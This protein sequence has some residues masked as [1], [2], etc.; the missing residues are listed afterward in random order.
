MPSNPGCPH[1]PRNIQV[2]KI[3]NVK[4][5][6]C[7]N[8]CVSKMFSSLGDGEMCRP[9]IVSSPVPFLDV[10]NSRHPCISLTC[11]GD[12]F[13]P[14]DVIINGGR[15]PEGSL[16]VVV[17]GPNM[18]GKST[19]M[20]QTGLLVILA[21]LV[22]GHSHSLPL[23]L[24]LSLFLSLSLLF[25]TMY[26]RVWMFKDLPLSVRVAMCQPAVVLSVQL[27]ESSPGLERLTKSHL[28]RIQ[29]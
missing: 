12:D 7:L 20:R 3:F 9:E 14:N 2:S 1:E 25:L 24:S 11:G 15:S 5:W 28:V 18:G 19:L 16:V 17:T 4:F 22:C 27:I 13:I 21:Q 10:M 23:S 8:F 29:Y 6:N 26:E